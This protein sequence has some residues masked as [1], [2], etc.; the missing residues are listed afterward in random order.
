MPV[1]ERILGTKSKVRILREL[2]RNLERDFSLED[3]V[4]ATNM[5]YGTI[6]PAINEL[7]DARIV[8][9][10]KAGSSKLYKMNSTHILFP[11]LASLMSREINAFRDIAYEIA[12][13]I[14]KNDIENIILFGS[15]ARGEV[16]DAGDIDLLIIYNDPKV[17]DKT[18]ALEEIILAKYDVL[19]SPLYIS[20]EEVMRK[21][22][23]FDDFILRIIDEGEIIYGDAKWLVE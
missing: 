12:D 2:I 23:S 18:D 1:I 19:F 22:K 5:S 20:K 16:T 6:H 10:R 13:N 9:V 17:I 4:N 15:V 21:I 14:E 8:L 3:I 11:E 7:A